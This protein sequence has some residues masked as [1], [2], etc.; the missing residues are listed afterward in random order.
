MPQLKEKFRH[1]FEHPKDWVEGLFSLSDWL[2]DAI[3]V[4]PKSCRTIT[5]GV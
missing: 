2:K 5:T 4:F 1:F 3:S